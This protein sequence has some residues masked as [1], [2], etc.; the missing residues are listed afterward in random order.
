[1]KS[2][3]FLILWVAAFFL[4]PTG[5]LM[6]GERCRLGAVKVCLNADGL[7]CI[8]G[9]VQGVLLEAGC[10]VEAIITDC[11]GNLLT[12]EARLRVDR[13]GRFQACLEVDVDELVDI[14]GNVVV[15]LNLF[16]RRGNCCDR[17]CGLFDLSLDLAALIDLD[18]V[19]GGLLGG[20]R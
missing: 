3:M 5:R 9:V 17:R 19:L 13:L 8:S 10:V 16:D 12:A 18:G 7:L 11:E 20:H 6:A 1:M 15:D 4:L 2:S 14:N